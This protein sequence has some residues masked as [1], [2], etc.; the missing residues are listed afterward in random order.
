MSQS[1][2]PVTDLVISFCLAS[3]GSDID[4]QDNL[5]TVPGQSRVDT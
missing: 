3:L 5:H 2:S 1:Q 4:N